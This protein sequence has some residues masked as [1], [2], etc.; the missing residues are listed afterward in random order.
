[1]K[2]HEKYIVLDRDGVINHDSDAFI[3]SPDEWIPIEGSLDAIIKLN[4]HGYKVLVCTNQS[5]IGRELFD[6]ATLNKIHQKMYD[7]LQQKGG[8][9]EAVFFC[10]HTQKDA[11][12]CRKP[13]SGMLEDIENRYNISLNNVAMVGD[14]LRDLQAGERMGMKP[15]LVLSGKGQKTFAEKKTELPKNTQVFHNLSAVVDFLIANS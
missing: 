9:I 4:R 3:K 5:G 12:L 1:M 7:L 6:M 14:S 2:T 8:K 11:C 13:L 10:P 15:F